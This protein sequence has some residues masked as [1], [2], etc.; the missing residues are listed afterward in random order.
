MEPKLHSSDYINAELIRYLTYGKAYKGVSMEFPVHIP[1]SSTYFADV[2][3][4]NKKRILVEYEIKTSYHDFLRDFSKP[5]HI[6]KDHVWGLKHDLLLSGLGPGV[7]YF[8][9]PHRCVGPWVEK[10]W[11]QL[12]LKP[13]GIIENGT[14][15]VKEASP[16]HDKPLT[17]KE[18]EFLYDHQ[19]F[20]LAKYYGKYIEQ[21]TAPS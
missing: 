15:I 4:I 2:V 12:T 20:C 8:V 11:S 5:I 13:Y 18:I 19:G 3:A 16:L 1:P 21:K 7:F 10:A 9:F 17:N 6:S 14:R